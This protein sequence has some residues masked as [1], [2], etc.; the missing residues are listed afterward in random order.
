M[1]NLQ[2][3]SGL[4]QLCYNGA[5][6]NHMASYHIS[7][8]RELSGSISIS[9][10][11]NAALPIIC[12]TLLTDEECILKNVPDIQDVRN[13]MEI[14]HGLGSEVSYRSNTLF[15]KNIGVNSF[16]PQAELVK[17]LRGSILLLGPLLSRFHKAKMPFPGGDV[18]GKR[19]IDTHLLALK[20]FGVKIEAN[21]FIDAHADKITGSEII[22]NEIS[23]TATENAIML[24]VLAE[25]MTQIHLAATEPHVQDLCRFLNKMGAKISG[26]STHDLVIEGVKQLHGTDHAIIFDDVVA[27]SFMSLAAATKSEMIIENIRPE[28]LY[29]P[30]NQFRRMNVNFEIGKDSIKIKKPLDS[31]KAAK[32]KAGLYPGLLSDYIPP[33]AVLATQA[34]GISV[35][36]EWMYEGRLGYIHELSKMGAKARI[37]DQHFAEIEGPCALNGTNV[38]SLD[39]RSGMVLIIA[40]LV[41]QGKSVLHDVEHLDRGY[42]NLESILVGVG[43]DIKRVEE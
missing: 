41:A 4:W 20:D 15:I 36:H 16:E 8:G 19:P 32:I 14:L 12:A 7:G 29:S 27:C 39:I 31:Y 43:A 18:I 37:M 25:G 23:V 38:S 33:F 22:L 2:W 6:E 24:A 40:A 34:E 35:I 13:L 28:F 1:P 42:E 3:H 21:G 17:K 30:M 11:K 26:I 5:E 9:G 10:S